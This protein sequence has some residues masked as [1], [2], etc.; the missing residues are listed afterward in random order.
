LWYGRIIK[1]LDAV[2]EEGSARDVPKRVD[3]DE[4]RREIV[5]ALCRIT[6]RG[7]LAAATMREVAAEA[8]V[9]VR[10]VQYYF[11]SKA[12]LLHAANQYVAE[13]A[14][15]RV[16]RAV[17]RLGDDPEPRAVVHAIVEQFIPR[18]T[19]RRTTLTLFYAFY[20]AQLTDASLRRS[21]ANRVPQSLARTVAAQLRAAQ[22]AGTAPADLDAER[23][24]SLL[25]GALPSIAS[26][27]LV[28]FMTLDEAT[29]VLRYAVD[30]L[31]EPV[32]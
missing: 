9:S 17:V 29:R 20:T 11:G 21:R 13:R 22:E 2:T 28:R 1:R 24:A 15:Q 14:A 19:E 16:T 10:L 18:D 6:V 8:G 23:E 31:F 26:G 5:G 3:H 7:G 12:E 30:R 4:R 25:T 27:V 32:R